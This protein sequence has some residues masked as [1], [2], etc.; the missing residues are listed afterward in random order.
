MTLFQAILTGERVQP[1]AGVDWT[2]KHVN[3]G[4]SINDPSEGIGTMVN[5]LLLF[6]VFFELYLKEN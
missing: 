1:V 5:V 3:T 6:N 2:R 4:F